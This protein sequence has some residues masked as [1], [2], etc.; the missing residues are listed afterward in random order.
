MIFFFPMFFIC[1][2]HPDRIP[3]LRLSP[4]VDRTAVAER[5][6][7]SI[8]QKKKKSCPITLL[9][10]AGAGTAHGSFFTQFTVMRPQT[11]PEKPLSPSRK[12][13]NHNKLPESVFSLRA[14]SAIAKHLSHTA[15]P[16]AL[17]SIQRGPRRP[18]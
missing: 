12:R 17:Q 18:S 9:L 3:E 8:C 13:N 2:G 16:P 15:A 11:N 1:C 7:T 14:P 6:R 5:E 10:F 4:E